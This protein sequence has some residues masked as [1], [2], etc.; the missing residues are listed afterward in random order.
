[1]CYERIFGMSFLFFAFLVG[2]FI[3]ICGSNQ[4]HAL[5]FGNDIKIASSDSGSA[6]MKGQVANTVKGDVYAAWVDQ[7]NIYFISSQQ[8]GTKFSTP[9]VLSNNNSNSSSPQI[10]ATEKGSVYVVWV[11]RNST[12][13][14]SNLVL[15]SSNNYGKNFANSFV[16]NKSPSL[17]E[18]FLSSAPQIAATE[19][20]SVYV[21]WVDKKKAT[22]DEDI[23]YTS[24]NDSGNHFESRKL[25]RSNDLLSFSPQIA[26]TE[27]G[28][29]YV[30]WVDRNNITGDSNLVFKS[31]NDYGKNFGEL[32]LLNKKKK[33]ISSTPQIAATEKG[34]VYVVWVDK[35]KATGDEDIAYTSSNDSGNHFESRKLLR[36]NDLRSFSPQ[37]AATE[38]G[39]VY[40]VWVDRNSTTEDSSLVFKSSNDYGKNFGDLVH[41]NKKK[42]IISSTPQIA[43]TEKGSVYVVWTDN[44]LQFKEIVK[45]GSIFGIAVPLSNNLMHPLSPQVL[46]TGNGDVYIIWLDKNSDTSDTRN[47]NDDSVLLFK[48]ASETFFDRNL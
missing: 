31:S 1:M 15:K 41:L 5:Y 26:A 10:A 7:G 9:V 45:N 36:S 39:S 48:K 19:K 8:N 42:K 22:G 4:V 32:V 28:S 43:A 30:V 20:G 47:T 27:K 38:K 44:T 13:G 34:S 33:I 18:S 24:S 14:D 46:A 6:L 16:L 3:I 40:I 37:I 21:V 17:N 25:L 12:T 35:K 11:D 2:L 29:V 23:A